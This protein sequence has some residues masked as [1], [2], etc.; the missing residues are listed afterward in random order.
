MVDSDKI[1]FPIKSLQGPIT[2][3]IENVIYA[4]FG[5]AVVVCA[6]LIENNQFPIFDLWAVL[7]FLTSTIICCLGFIIVLCFERQQGLKS[8][9]LKPIS[10]SHHNITTV[11]LVVY[12]LVSVKALYNSKWAVAFFPVSQSSL[13]LN[14]AAGLS[15]IVIAW[16]MSAILTY[17]STPF[18][19]SNSMFFNLPTIAGVTIVFIITNSVA[20]W[21]IMICGLILEKAVVAVVAVTAVAWSSVFSILDAVSFKIQEQD[22]EV[23]WYNMGHMISIILIVFMHFLLAEITEITGQFS[24]VL[25]VTAL[26]VF[27]FNS[28]PLLNWIELLFNYSSKNRTESK[29]KNNSSHHHGHAHSHSH[30]KVTQDT[31]FKMPF[32]YQHAQPPRPPT[33]PPPRQSS[34]DTFW[35]MPRSATADPAIWKRTATS[36]AR[37]FTDKNEPSKYG[38]RSPIN[39]YPYNSNLKNE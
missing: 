26:T 36:A 27:C 28:T 37:A 31:E 16:M 38:K 8:K 30:T 21:K 34:S 32:L 35:Q 11:I 7:S 18:G 33:Y 19:E 2:W 25:I 6:R 1:Y 13:S 12:V 3:L 20:T 10:Q 4:L 17:A 15:Y 14:I 9:Y 22:M 5:A 29:S 24:Y 39:L 23:R